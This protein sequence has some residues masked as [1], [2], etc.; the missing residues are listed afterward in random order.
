MVCEYVCLCVCVCECVSVMFLNA[1]LIRQT[2][3]I[4]GFIPYAFLFRTAYPLRRTL[5]HRNS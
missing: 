2:L 3:D 1:I 4:N 5:T